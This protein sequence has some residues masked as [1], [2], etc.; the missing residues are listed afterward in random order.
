[1]NVFRASAMRLKSLTRRRCAGKIGKY[2]NHPDRSLHFAAIR[3]LGQCGGEEAFDLLA[4]QLRSSDP[5][6]RAEAANALGIGKGSREP[7]NR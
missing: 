3:A 4:G 1:M 7:S 5:E 2:L 6:T